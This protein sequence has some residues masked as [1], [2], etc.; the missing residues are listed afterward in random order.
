GAIRS[1]VCDTWAVIGHGGDGL[2]RLL[3][4]RPGLFA[5]AR[6]Q[7]WTVACPL[8]AA[9]DPHPHEPDPVLGEER[10]SASRV[11][12]PRVAAIDDRIAWRKLRQQRGYHGVH[13][14]PSRYH[15]QDAPRLLYPL[16]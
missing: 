9:R 1:H 3:D 4:E 15:H 10:F 8:F 13:G 11:F 7:T 6:H 14:F 12:E 2:E 16:H 5:S